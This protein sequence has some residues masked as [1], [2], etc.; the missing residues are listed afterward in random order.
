MDNII[1]DTSQEAGNPFNPAK[2]T[3]LTFLYVAKCKVAGYGSVEWI[4]FRY[5]ATLDSVHI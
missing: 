2:P 1:L 3:D 4:T 5:F